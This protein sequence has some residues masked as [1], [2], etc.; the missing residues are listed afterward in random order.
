M[1]EREAEITAL[2]EQETGETVKAV[3][4]LGFNLWAVT[5]TAGNTYHVS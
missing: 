2:V 4:Q 1:K 5:T 3:F